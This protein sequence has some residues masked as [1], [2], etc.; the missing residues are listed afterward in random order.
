MKPHPALSEASLLRDWRVLC[1]EIGERRAGSAGERRAAE[2]VAGRFAALGLR[3]VATEEFPCTSL[4]RARSR[5]QAW[6]S[7][8]WHTAETQALVGAP[9]T[10][11]GR[12]VEGE[13][14]SLEMPADLPLLT[15]GALRGKI[16]VLFGPLPT[17]VEQHRR[18]VA[19]SPLAVVHVDER[20]PFA[21]AK[22]DGVYPAWV[23]RHGMP[24][25]V[26]VPYLTAWQWRLAGVR[27]LRVSAAVELRAARSQNVIG[28]LPGSLP[29][30]PA[31]VLTA[32]HDTQCGNPGADDNASGVV[33][34]LALAGTL[35]AM[36]RRRTIRFISFG[37]EEQLSVGSA[38]YVRAHRA[39]LRAVGLEVNF[40]SVASPLG[41][42][43]MWRTGPAA[44]ETWAV[45]RLAR[46]GLRV[47]AHAEVTP[48]FDTFPFNQAGVPSLGFYRPNFSG[49]R[50]QHHSRHDTLAH[51]SPAE[52]ARL[53]A[54]V[55]PLVRDLAAQRVWPFRRALPAGQRQV[56]RQLARE[57]FEF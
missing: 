28:E 21:W 36:P 7:G 26:T 14:V 57:L 51:V 33:C 48:F 56:A 39:A 10:P 9:G 34:L 30:L 19:A 16:A 2:F 13:T 4:A 55:A 15:R 18:L 37:C 31:L 38:A 45:R 12:A 20:L 32:H 22:S 3:R 46:A 40:D 41:H 53:V 23:K 43:E 29:R 5:V 54:A 17:R 35:A 1:E 24:T 50:W 27:R 49:G 6:F 25:T 44:L 8:R 11:G 52:V 47:R 42:W